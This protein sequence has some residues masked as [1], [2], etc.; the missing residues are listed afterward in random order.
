[1]NRFALEITFIVISTNLQTKIHSQ[2]NKILLHCIAIKIINKVHAIT[3][4]L[5]SQIRRCQN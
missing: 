3:K 5:F 2:P 4:N 1:M